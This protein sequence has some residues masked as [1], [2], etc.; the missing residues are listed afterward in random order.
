M[1]KNINDK[2]ICM[3]ENSKIININN[4]KL[5]IDNKLIKYSTLYTNPYFLKKKLIKNIKFYPTQNNLI[6]NLCNKIFLLSNNLSEYDYKNL[7]QIIKKK[8]KYYN[9]GSIGF[10]HCLLILWFLIYIDKNIITEQKKIYYD[11]IKK[12]YFK[13]NENSFNID[14]I[15]YNMLNEKNIILKKFNVS[16]Y[17]LFEEFHFK[18]I[19]EYLKNQKKFNIIFSS[20]YIKINPQYILNNFKDTFIHTVNSINE[21]LS[22]PFGHNILLIKSNLSRVYYYDP[23]E[24]V[25][26]DLYK[27]K[28]LFNLNDID[29]FNIS[30]RNPIQGITDDSN[31][32]FYCLG[33]IKWISKNNIMKIIELNTLKKFVLEFESFLYLENINIFNWIIL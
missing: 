29:F 26:S 17:I 27:F 5:M 6:K 15:I 33:F 28:T 19:S 10:E 4:F 22:N 7:Y 32:V 20:N 11:I 24:Q 3:I 16:F 31:C 13:F 21:D 30:N 23:D 18:Y 2:A 8:Q 14:E 9:Y 25:L 12:F 1:L